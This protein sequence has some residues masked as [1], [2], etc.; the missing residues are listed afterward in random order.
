M[1]QLIQRLLLN[2]ADTFTG[3][4]DVFTNF[5]QGAGFIRAHPETLA[6]NG[7]FLGIQFRQNLGDNFTQLLLRRRN[8]RILRS[9][10]RYVFNTTAVLVGSN[11]CLY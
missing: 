9:F 1:L 5:F 11:G 3:D 4:A 6:Q 2:L 7:F 8:T 10:I